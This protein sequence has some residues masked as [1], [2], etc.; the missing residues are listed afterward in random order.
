MSRRSPIRE[1]VVS[2]GTPVVRCAWA[3]RD[4][5][6]MAYHDEEWGVPLRDDRSLFELLVLEG[7]Q[8]GL[9]WTT[10]IRKRTGYRQAFAGFDPEVVACFTEADC[11]HLLHNPGIV[12]H[13]GK[14]RAAVQIARTVLAIQAEHGSFSR[15]VWSFVDGAPRQH[16]WRALA[17]VPSRSPE[18]DALSRDLRRRGCAFVGSTICYAFMQAAGLMNDHVVECFRWDEIRRLHAL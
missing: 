8:A 14:I 12:R 3:H 4:P 10:I 11:E 9:S 1:A 5:L 2:N 7:A 16:T 13:Q 17:E 6:E 18:S 15:Y